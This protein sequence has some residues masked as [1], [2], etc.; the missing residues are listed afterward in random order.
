LASSVVIEVAAPDAAERGLFKPAA[1]AAGTLTI[2]EV[3]A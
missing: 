2:P 1:A 3:E